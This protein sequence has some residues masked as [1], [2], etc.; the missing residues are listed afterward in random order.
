MKCLKKNHVYYDNK[1]VPCLAR[2]RPFLT[3]LRAILEELNLNSSGNKEVL[4]SRLAN[5]TQENP[6]S[7]PKN[8]DKTENKKHSAKHKPTQKKSSK[9]D[10][11]FELENNCP[12]PDSFKLNVT[13][14]QE[15]ESSPINWNR[16]LESLKTYIDQ[17]NPCAIDF[18]SLTKER[19]CVDRVFTPEN[20]YLD[21]LYIENLLQSSKRSEIM[22]ENHVLFFLTVQWEDEKRKP[23]EDLVGFALGYAKP[24]TPKIFTIDL[25]CTSLQ[26]PTLSMECLPKNLRLGS[27]LIKY[28]QRWAK[29]QKFK[30]ILLHAILSAEMFYLKMGF[31]YAKQCRKK[32][33]LVNCNDP[34]RKFD[35]QDQTVEMIYCL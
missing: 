3:E 2:K 17:K 9:H 34:H 8:P 22:F 14:I 20:Y 28:I 7:N 16:H 24:S 11:K 10:S 15:A 32:N 30:K 19:V 18:K 21:P 26:I 33:D 31:Q 5:L 29:Q 1:C 23:Q 6:G 25:L 4:C 35:A 12:S 13:V 27:T